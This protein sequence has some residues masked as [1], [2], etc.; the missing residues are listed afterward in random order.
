MAT[1]EPGGRGSGRTRSGGVRLAARIERFRR[2]AM[3]LPEVVERPHWDMP[4]FRVN[5]KIFA[6]IHEDKGLGM[7]KLTPDQQEEWEER[8]PSVITPVPGGWGRGGATFI[9]LRAASAATVR[10]TLRTAWGNVA[11][12]RLVR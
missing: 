8:E 4:S 10:A 5:T 12:K 6:T 11:P 2:L 7:V 3:A 1:T 9:D